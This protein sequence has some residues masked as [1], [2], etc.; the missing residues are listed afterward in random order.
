MSLVKM[1][2]DSRTVYL[3]LLELPKT[4]VSLPLGHSHLLKS[5]G[6]VK[7]TVSGGTVPQLL[8]VILLL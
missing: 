2:G 8:M 4:E 5:S 1:L 3:N 7:A 6:L